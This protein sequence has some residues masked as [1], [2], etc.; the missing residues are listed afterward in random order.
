[1]GWNEKLCGLVP[2]R[3]ILSGIKK[4]ISHESYGI[5]LWIYRTDLFRGIPERAQ[6][7]Y[8]QTYGPNGV[9]SASLCI[10][11]RRRRYHYQNALD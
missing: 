10:L 6:G 3:K 4:H 7:K 9:L 8:F 5:D 1:M 2:R 11:G